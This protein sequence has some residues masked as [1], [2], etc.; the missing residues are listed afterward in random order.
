MDTNDLTAAELYAV[1]SLTKAAGKRRRELTA[2]THNVD[3]AVR[4]KGTVTV[5][6]DQSIETAGAPSARAVAAVLLSQLGPRVR[7]RFVDELATRA[8]GPPRIDDDDLV[9]QLIDA[10]STPAH[11]TRRGSVAAKVELE[12]VGCGG[13]PAGQ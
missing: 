5:N 7:K 12:A 2:G 10:L 13:C 8:D 11:A 1:G 3:V 9:D 4:V 6:A